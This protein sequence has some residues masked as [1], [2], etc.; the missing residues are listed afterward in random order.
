M[1]LR[2]SFKGFSVTKVIYSNEITIAT[3]IR[4]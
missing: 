4:D 1:H 2:I 3:D